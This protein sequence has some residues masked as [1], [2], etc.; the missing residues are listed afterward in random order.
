M[1]DNL[2]SKPFSPSHSTVIFNSQFFNLGFYGI[3]FELLIICYFRGLHTYPAL[4]AR[5]L[6]LLVENK[7]KMRKS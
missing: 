2:R 5:V 7:E 3:L 1:G 4:D 6:P